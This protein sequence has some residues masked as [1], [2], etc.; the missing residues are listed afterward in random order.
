M[1][2]YN[3]YC[4]PQQEHTTRNTILLL[5]VSALVFIVLMLIV[6]I[7]SEPSAKVYGSET[8]YWYGL[9]VGITVMSAYI[10]SRSLYTLYK[11]ID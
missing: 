7:P 5:V 6:W 10:Q 3:C 4:P 8:S 9:A 11:K 2:D 1:A